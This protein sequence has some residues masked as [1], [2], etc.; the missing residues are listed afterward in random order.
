MD[1]FFLDEV[2]ICQELLRENTTNHSKEQKKRDRITKKC[3]KMFAQNKTKR[4]ERKTRTEKN[5]CQNANR[6]M[7]E[8]SSFILPKKKMFIIYCLTTLRK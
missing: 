1:V 2:K 5:T 4:K 6:K 7:Y 8:E 3:T